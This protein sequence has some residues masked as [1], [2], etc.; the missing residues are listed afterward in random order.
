MSELADWFFCTTMRLSPADT[1]ALLGTLAVVRRRR[2][3]LVDVLDAA[4]SLTSAP[5]WIQVYALRPLFTAHGRLAEQAR[6]DGGLDVDGLDD[7][8]GGQ[9]D[10]EGDI[11]YGDSELGRRIG[12]LCDAA[13]ATTEHP[14]AA[15]LSALL[16]AVV[17]DEEGAQAALIK[18]IASPLAGETP[19]IAGSVR[20]LPYHDLNDQI[21]PTLTIIALGELARRRPNSAASDWTG[22][23]AIP[24][25]SAALRGEYGRLALLTA[26][27]AATRADVQARD[28]LWRNLWRDGH[29][30]PQLQPDLLDAL[31]RLWF[32]QADSD[33]PPSVSA[34]EVEAITGDDLALWS[35]YLQPDNEVTA[36]FYFLLTGHAHGVPQAMAAVLWQSVLWALAAEVDPVDTAARLARWWQSPRTVSP[37]GHTAVHVGR[38]RTNAAGYLRNFSQLRSPRSPSLTVDDAPVSDTTPDAG[39][40]V[41]SPWVDRWHDGWNHGRKEE[42]AFKPPRSGYAEPLVRLFAAVSTSASLLA[43]IPPSA[44]EGGYDHLIALLFHGLDVLRDHSELLSALELGDYV[45]EHWLGHAIASLLWHAHQVLM[46]A[47]AG[48]NERIDPLVI[49]DYAVRVLE[50]GSSADIQ[51]HEQAARLARHGVSAISVIWIRRAWVESS[52]T[53]KDQGCARWFAGDPPYALRVLLAALDRLSLLETQV[54]SLRRQEGQRRSELH[55]QHKK[56]GRT[57]KPNIGVPLTRGIWLPDLMPAAQLLREIYPDDWPEP[58]GSRWP[59]LAIDWNGQRRGL[60][61]HFQALLKAADGKLEAVRENSVRTERLLLSPQYPLEVWREASPQLE[62][63][64]RVDSPPIVMRALRLSALLRE[65]TAV[66]AP[67]YQEWIEDW[68]DRLYAVAGGQQLPLDVRTLMIRFFGLAAAGPA[69]AVYEQRLSAVHEATIDAILEFG[70]ATPRYIDEL[71]GQLAATLGLG[72]ESTAR[73]RL[74]GLETIYRQRQY[75]TP[76]ARLGSAS[77]LRRRRVAGENL[78]RAIRRYLWAVVS[79][80][81]Q[82]K[83]LIPLRERVRD[84]WEHVQSRPG[85]Q[86]RRTPLADQRRERGERV[87]E[88]LVAASVTDRFR[89]REIS[90]VLDVATDG[91]HGA[92]GENGRLHNLFPSAEY[93]RRTLK[94]IAQSGGMALAVVAG[95]DDTR[96]WLNAGLGRLLPY[97]SVPTDPPLAAGDVTAVRLLG[98]PA[99]VTGIRQLR[100]PSPVPGEVRSATLL[101]DAPWL[102]LRVD[103]IGFDVYPTSEGPTAEAVRRLWDPD[104]SRAFAPADPHWRPVLARWDAELGHWLPLERQLSELMADEPD[105]SVPIRL[106]HAG[107]DHFVTR[108]GWLYRI[109]ASDWQDPE[110]A[111]RLL[112]DQPSGL[113]LEASLALADVPRLELTGHDDRN[114]RWSRQFTGAEHEFTVATRGEAGG[115][116]LDVDSPPGFPVVVAVR[117]AE[118]GGQRAYVITSPWSDR[119]ARLGEVSV[120]LVPI[121]GVAQPQSPTSERFEDLYTV[122]KGRV[123]TLTRIFSTSVD[124][125]LVWA[126]TSTELAVRLETDSFTLLDPHLVD[127][128]ARGFVHGRPAEVVRVYRPAVPGQAGPAM[129]D[130]DFLTRVHTPGV[131]PAD[132]EPAL[133]ATADIEGVV[134]TRAAVPG[135]GGETTRYG[136]WCRFGGHVHYVELEQECFG[137]TYAQLVG[138]TFTGSR[139]GP[140]TWTFRFTRREV[141]VRALFELRDAADGDGQ[142][143]FVG[144]DGVND[145]YQARSGPVVTRRPATAGDPARRLNLLGGHVTLID[146]RRL[147]SRTIAVRTLD[148]TRVLLGTT[149]FSGDMASA[150]ASGAKLRV[151]TPLSRAPGHVH[152]RRTFAVSVAAATSTPRAR[153][154]DHAERWQRFLASGEEHVTGALVDR[155][156]YIEVAGGLRPPGPDGRLSRLLPVI[157]GEEPA[158]AGVK[159]RSIDARV[160]LVPQGDGYAASF[161]TAVPK[162]LRQFMRQM[163]QELSDGNVPRPFPHGLYYVGPPTAELDAHVFEWGYGWTVAVPAA[164]LRVDGSAD[165]AGLPALFHGDQVQAASFVP[166]EDG[167]PVMVVERR[168]IRQ[169]YV[170]RV[171]QEGGQDHLHLVDIE[172]SVAAGTLRVIRAQAGRQQSGD[173]P[174]RSAEWVPFTASLDEAS[175]AQIMEWLRDAGES[176]PVKRRIL[177]R[178]DTSLAISTGGRERQFRAIRAGENGLRD[179]DRVFLT[180]TDVEETSNELTLIFGIPDA[181][182]AD[183]LVVRVNRREFSFREDTLARLLARGLDVK[184]GGVVMLVRVSAAD[185]RGTRRGSTW[186]VPVRRQETLVSYLAS[187]GGACYAILGR[188]REGVRLEIA[189][190]VIYSATG[191][192]STDWT[193]P[194]AVV[195]LVLGEQRRMVM[196]TALSADRSYVPEHG[197]PAVVLPKSRLLRNDPAERG[198]TMRRAFTV[199]GLSDV[200]ASPAG[201]V[202][203]TVLAAPHPKI[204]VIRQ[205]ADGEVMLRVPRPGEVLMGRLAGNDPALPAVIRIR[206]LPGQER[207]DNEAIEVPWARMSFHN[208]TVRE[209]AKACLEH[210]WKHHDRMTGH[211]RDERPVRYQLSP[212]TARSEGV[213]FDQDQGWTLRYAP[214][215]LAAFGFPAS[216]LIDEVGNGRVL[217]VAGVSADGGGIWVELGPG[218]VAE[219][220]GALVTADGQL[221]LASLNWSAFSSGDQIGL[222]P[223]RGDRAAGDWDV[224]PG[225]LILTRWRPS[226]AAALPHGDPDA[227]ILLPIR[228]TAA[229]GGGLYLGE[230]NWRMTFPLALSSVPDYEDVPAVWLNRRNDIEAAAGSPPRPGDTVLLGATADGQLSVDGLPGFTVRL[231]P[232]AKADW[233]GYGWLH[234]TLEEPSERG[235]LLAALGG[236]LPVT[237]DDV[238]LDEQ[239]INISRARQPS[240]DWPRNRLVRADVIN[241]HR[242]R[243][244]LQSGGALYSVHVRDAVAGIRPDQAAPVARALAALPAASRPALWWLVG[245]DGQLQAGWSG[246]SRETASA[247]TTVV[248]EFEVTDDGVAAGVVCREVATARLRWLPAGHASWVRDMPAK[249]LLANLAQAGRLNAR[250]L[251]DG[252]LSITTRPAVSHLIQR[253]DLGH[254][255]RVVLGTSK[256]WQT[257]DG[258][259]RYVARLEVP[260]VLLAYDATDPELAPG[261]SLLAEVDDLDRTGRPAVTTV[262]I[263]SRMVRLDLPAWLSAAHQSIAQGDC[264]AAGAQRF[265]QYR[266]WY[267]DGLSGLG[268]PED[269]VES[270]LR[271]AGDLSDSSAVPSLDVVAEVSRRWLALQGEAV[272]NLVPEVEL[273]AAPLLAGAVALDALAQVDPRWE[274]AAVLCLRQLGRRATASTHTEQFATAWVNRPER[275]ALGGAWARLRELSLPHELDARQVRQLQQFCQAM[276]TR[277]ALRIKESDLAPVSRSLLA[278]IGGLDSAQELLGDAPALSSLAVWARALLPAANDATS[279]PRLLPF[280]RDQL[281]AAAEHVISDAVPLTLLPVTAPPS[282]RERELARRLVNEVRGAE[283]PG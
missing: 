22:D 173:D 279:Q 121:R 221:S 211:I 244:L 179:H 260:P 1:H 11:Q 12:Q 14:L 210:E 53:E 24:L 258:R 164:Q 55:R 126:N 200:E 180:A 87:P 109:N 147:G 235:P 136:T 240:G 115:Y 198:G 246:D 129:P 176:G 265:S 19:R 157:P 148:R 236:R 17:R 151:S 274:R 278:A 74:R 239:V 67:E 79:P 62:L 44:T 39:S 132:L 196:S 277:P 261:S 171:V 214:D 203:P 124:S 204:C 263:S 100:R 144:S 189:P 231:A 36:E 172:V 81:G 255:L 150:Q 30:A 218:R 40:A 111:A 83:E 116:S 31:A 206:P 25:L 47:G 264:P 146:R 215:R 70:W 134:V 95:A 101:A 156:R 61:H 233:P 248:P 174:F 139:A 152:V 270:V 71:L 199:S 222:R 253:L 60:D 92:S 77:E 48:R 283:V 64:T 245:R 106:V 93:Q 50:D 223:A 276:L 195:R 142:E 153:Q 133:S 162:N 184:S 163:G 159:Y 27:D 143:E 88:I 262:E 190:G 84:L 89:A 41:C 43:E 205:T 191:I 228:G 28:E 69:D 225:H 58:V 161:Q 82:P 182:N 4:A 94:N 20:G 90:Y 78:D 108:P 102:K 158:V 212:G 15:P 110:V 80:A 186:D 177:A 9:G 122:E 254:S 249:A 51:L 10:Y 166:G 75:P 18:D 209:L 216:S 45:G 168:N 32:G 103:G 213:F 29:G 183:D 85:L 259:W 38:P 220:R 165:P 194:G 237:V 65:P 104:L 34:L 181:M 46:D 232:P 188:T 105:L 281:R 272:Y 5:P 280:Q 141:T 282:R 193:D 170:T 131:V 49:A 72:P 227:R 2:P 76:A 113:V 63:W 97:D 73:L 130:A 275:H 155:D 175:V 56:D 207:G 54:R 98:E 123:L 226:V 243:L 145:L 96:V 230:G 86:A 251:D 201:R 13:L 52:G 252:S 125:A 42:P 266:Q 241:A 250:G 91:N 187:R 268:L 117:G 6:S 66:A 257:Q 154:V 107:G 26:V 256:P 137:D 127:R 271:L 178:F 3:E 247:E 149:T 33:D 242:E 273:D 7:A 21:V 192:S 23:A 112:R 269:P 138:Q 16:A 234:R 160:R 185:S 169:R 35:R 140:G 224:G 118:G 119:Q 197:R 59:Q 68:L 267:R 219:V 128:S 229:N 57:G 202:G 167:E 120:T 135:H 37:G 114:L 217:A 8:D 238:R 208:T 99:A